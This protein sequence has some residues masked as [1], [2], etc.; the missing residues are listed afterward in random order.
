MERKFTALRIISVLFKILGVLIGIVTVLGIV[1]VFIAPPLTINFGI[2]T[3]SNSLLSLLSSAVLAV[4]DLVVGVLIAFG[5]Y[6]TGDLIILLV[7]VEENTRFTA[8]ILRDRSMQPAQPVP[9]APQ[10]APQ[11]LPPLMQPYQRSAAQ[12]V[13]PPMPQPYQPPVQPSTI[14]VPPPPPSPMQPPMQPPTIQAPPPSPPP[15]IQVPPSPPS[16][17]DSQS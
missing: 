1:W 8:L 11:P 15:T 6:G 10:P 13:Q 17:P 7:K 5:V 4:L 9:P 12:P 16:P 3:L 2:G 14:Q